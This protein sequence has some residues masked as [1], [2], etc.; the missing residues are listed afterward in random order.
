MSEKTS[1]QTLSALSNSMDQESAAVTA[2]R[3][4]DPIS[5]IEG[6]LTEF[7]RDSFK[8]VQENRSFEAEIKDAILIRLGEA[9]VKQLMD[10]YTQVQS[11]NTGAAQSIINPIM[12]IQAAKVAAEVEAH[13]LPGANFVDERVF[14]K[15][16]KDVLQGIVQ[17]NQLLEAMHGNN[18]ALTPDVVDDKVKK[19]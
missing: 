19:S 8:H 3:I 10:F 9:N 1:I 12:G 11:G 6:S 18:S 14:K 2:V 15:A 5:S 7:V 17:L 13:T 4:D 16:S